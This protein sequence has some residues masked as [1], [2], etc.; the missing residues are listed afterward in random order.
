M[1]ARLSTANTDTKPFE[2]CADLMPFAQ[3]P[4]HIEGDMRVRLRTKPKIRHVSHPASPPS[5]GQWLTPINVIPISASR[6]C[7]IFNKESS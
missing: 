3:Q 4:L 1:G 5:S 7:Q 6:E 2:L